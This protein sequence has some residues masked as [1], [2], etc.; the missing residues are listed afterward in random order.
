MV[1]YFPSSCDFSSEDVSLV[2]ESAEKPAFDILSKN[3]GWERC[4]AEAEGNEEENFLIMLDFFLH[5][6]PSSSFCRIFLFSLWWWYGKLRGRLWLL[7]EF[8][9][10]HII[11]VSFSP[12]AKKKLEWVKSGNGILGNWNTF[13]FLLWLSSLGWISWKKF[14]H[15]ERFF[16]HFTWKLSC[17][18]FMPLLFKVEGG[19]KVMKETQK[20]QHNVSVKKWTPTKKKS[21]SRNGGFEFWEG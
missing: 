15:F 9:I 20:K 12:S 17:L 18:L 21:P 4:W 3:G 11:F 6:L 16:F 5:F 19:K 8:F 2:L 7:W 14:P 10:L 13:F 1:W